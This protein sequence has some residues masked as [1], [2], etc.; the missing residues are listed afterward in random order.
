MLV[1]PEHP[2]R[3]FDLWCEADGGIRV[4]AGTGQSYVLTHVGALVFLAADGTKSRADIVTC[5]ARD[6]GWGEGE[7]SPLVEERLAVLHELDVV[8]QDWRSW[9]DDA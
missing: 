4:L 6:T 5:I 8:R 2:R 1:M 9:G 7:L 3:L